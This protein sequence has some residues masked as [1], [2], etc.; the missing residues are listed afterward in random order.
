MTHPPVVFVH[1]LWIHAAS[2]GP[3]IERFGAAGYRGDGRG[4]ARRPGDRRRS[5]GGPAIDRRP[6]HRGDRRAPQAVH[7]RARRAADP[8]RAFLRRADHPAVAGR[9]FRRRRRRDRPGADQR[10]AAPSGFLAQGRVAG[11]AEAG[12]PPPRRI[13]HQGTNSATDSATR[14]RRKNPTSSSR[15]GPSPVRG[16]RCS[17]RPSRPSP[18]IHRP[19]WTRR[20]PPAGRCCSSRAAGTTPCRP[21]SC[22]RRTAATGAPPPS[23]TSWSSPIAVIA[24]PWTR[25]GRRSP[26]Q[27]S[28]G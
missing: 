4:L 20:T 15:G 22:A 19:G 5:Q 24:S 18:C 23:P 11:A 6:R 16:G 3:W 28:T 12:Q 27:R 13:A 1:G 25:A 2:W 9:G 21:P 17:S 8:G 10:C 7:R 14:S 26:T